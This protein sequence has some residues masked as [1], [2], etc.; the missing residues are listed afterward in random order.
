[1]PYATSG[2]VRIHYEVEGSGPPLMLHTGFVCT[3]QDW[4]PL[5]YVDALKDDYQLILIDPRGQ[6]DSDKPHAPEAYEPRN[7]VADVIA[8]LD[9]VNADRA[10]FWGCSM[11][12]RI[13]FDLA[14]QRPERLTSLVLEGAHPFGNALDDHAALREA[15]R[16]GM[17]RFL[18][19]NREVFGR[20]P[21]EILDH[22][23]STSDPEALGAALV[24]E[25][26]LEA[27]LPDIRIPALLYCGEGDGGHDKA[28]RAA[29]IMPEATF[30]LLPGLDH[31]GAYIASGVSVPHV[32][33]FLSRMADSAA[34]SQSSLGR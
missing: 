21:K 32:R 14:L 19:A 18:D 23:I 28:R 12:G 30:V 10:H 6:G 24:R 25:P 11:G 7:R 17:A 27:E 22:W 15:L 5:G 1:M 33:A 3:A 8:V 4:Y 20:L 2:G 29:E 16:Q 13:G 26:S 31:L 34:P 9:A